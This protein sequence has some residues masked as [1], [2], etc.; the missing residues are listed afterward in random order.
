MSATYLTVNSRAQLA[1]ELSELA[2]KHKKD[3]EQLVSDQHMQHQGIYSFF[4]NPLNFYLFL[5]L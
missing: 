1:K 5:Y 4:F 3:C 2:Q